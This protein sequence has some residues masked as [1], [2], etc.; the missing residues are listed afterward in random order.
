MRIALSLVAAAALSACAAV[1]PA[2]QQGAQPTVQIALPPAQLY[3]IPEVRFTALPP[4][5][6]PA[7]VQ[8]RL[9]KMPYAEV[10]RW[11]LPEHAATTTRVELLSFWMPEI[12][13]GWFYETPFVTQFPGVCEVRARGVNFR[14]H[15]ER[16]L[17]YQQHLDPPL[18][19]YQVH[20]TRRFR[21][22]GSTLELGAATSASCAATLPYKDWFEAPSAESVWRAVQH[23]D[24][25]RGWPRDFTLTC[26]EQFYEEK[27]NSHGVRPCDARAYLEK[28]TPNLIKRIEGVPCEGKLAARTHPD[29]CWRLTYHDPRGVGTSSEFHVLATAGIV[30]MSQELLPPH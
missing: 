22:L 26:T 29:P 25:A 5:E 11:A 19:P 16:T 18:E 6:P 8:S 21:V 20:D 17:T 27:T 23:I 2:S 4:R 14:K 13:L 28:L 7:I 15:N 1:P 12:T 30:A 9:V 24:R 3:V 10:A